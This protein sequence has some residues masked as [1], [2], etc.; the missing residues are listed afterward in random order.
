LQVLGALVVLGGLSVLRK[1][2]PGK[3]K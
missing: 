1:I 2:L 3:R